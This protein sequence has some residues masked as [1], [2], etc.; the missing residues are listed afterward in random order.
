MKYMTDYMLS[1]DEQYDKQAAGLRN[2]IH[3]TE[4]AEIY[5]RKLHVHFAKAQAR[6]A[7]TESRETA[8]VEALKTA[9]DHHI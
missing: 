6:A 7:T 9:E 2:C 5:A 1:L 8:I 4:E 3:R